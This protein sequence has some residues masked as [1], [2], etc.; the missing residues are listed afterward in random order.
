MS[1]K[2]L[3]TELH[4]SVSSIGING[5]IE[6]LKKGRKKQLSAVC[7]NYVFVQ[8]NKMLSITAEQL[9]Q[10]N[11]HND[12]KKIAIGFYFYFSCIL[13]GYRFSE[14]CECLPIKL[15]KRALYYYFNII[16]TAKLVNPK[17]DID[18]L[19]V[20]H[21]AKLEKLFTEYKKLNDT[22]GKN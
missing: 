9:Q 1:E 5:T 3:I 20:L 12:V 22:D 11:G 8:V 14:V 10:R 17:T 13:L 16:K 2:T 21:F 4:H 6:V 18:K 19:I 7:I 15:K